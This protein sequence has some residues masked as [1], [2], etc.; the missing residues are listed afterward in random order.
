M[1][2]VLVGAQAKDVLQQIGS[3]NKISKGGNIV[4][5][6][7]PGRISEI[8][9]KGFYRIYKTCKISEIDFNVNSE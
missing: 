2:L 4:R 5:C 6:S 8:V 1:H 9:D 3:A 7:P